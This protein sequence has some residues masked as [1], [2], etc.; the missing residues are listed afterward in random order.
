VTED[1]REQGQEKYLRG[2]E[3]SKRK[4]KKYRAG[5]E[6][7]HCEFCWTKFCEEG[8]AEAKDGG[9]LFEGYAT[10]DEYRWVCESCFRDFREKYRFRVRPPNLAIAPK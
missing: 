4:Y 7:D 8:S 2:A 3:F 6:H 1:W 5:W 9:C 10:L